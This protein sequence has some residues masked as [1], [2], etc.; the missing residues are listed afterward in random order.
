VRQYTLLLS[1]DQFDLDQPI[2]V[3]TNGVVSF[4][5]RVEKQ[6]GTLLKWA[7]LDRDRT[8]TFLAELQIRLTGTN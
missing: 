1:P 7:A 2:R 6:I 4:E 8:M 3:L 5:G